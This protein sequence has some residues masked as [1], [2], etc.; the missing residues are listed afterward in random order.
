MNEWVVWNIVAAAIWISAPHHTRERCEWIR[1]VVGLQN[2]IE[3]R[4]R[5][6]A[7]LLSYDYVTMVKINFS[8]LTVWWW[9]CWWTIWNGNVTKKHYNYS[10]APHVRTPYVGI[11]SQMHV[12]ARQSISHWVVSEWRRVQCA[13]SIDRR[14]KRWVHNAQPHRPSIPPKHTIIKPTP[15]TVHHMV[16]GISCAFHVVRSADSND[17][18]NIWYHFFL[19]AFSLTG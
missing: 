16:L 1:W 11:I 15:T 17:P 12:H 8:M 9:C 13:R 6:H 14:E 7:T 4:A 19:L 2:E 18:T 5:F 3:Q 10:Q